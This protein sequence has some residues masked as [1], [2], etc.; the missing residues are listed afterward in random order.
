MRRADLIVLSLVTTFVVPLVA[1]MIGDGLIFAAPVLSGV[2]I[3]VFLRRT[4][5]RVGV[6]LAFALAPP[7]ALVGY[8]LAR[9]DSWMAH[10]AMVFA[11]FVGFEVLC[12][13]IGVA[14]GAR[15]TNRPSASNV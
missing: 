1:L 4:G 11:M 9:D 6:T 2:A 13:L 15:S 10:R 3:A 8:R 14:I 7:I 5:T 12:G